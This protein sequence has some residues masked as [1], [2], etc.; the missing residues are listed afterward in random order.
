MRENLKLFGMAHL[1]S[2][3][4]CRRNRRHGNKLEN[5]QPYI[6][7][8]EYLSPARAQKVLRARGTFLQHRKTDRVL[9]FSHGDQAH[10]L[11]LWWLNFRLVAISSSQETVS[12]STTAVQNGKH[13]RVSFGVRAVRNPGS[14]AI[15]WERE[16]TVFLNCFF[17]QSLCSTGLQVS[18]NP[19]T[20]GFVVRSA[21]HDCRLCFLGG[22]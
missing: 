20:A 6:E 13:R 9:A 4:C 3:L 22:Q 7:R 18:C 10:T 19:R 21:W 1:G 11:Y 17:A 16:S 5:V 8:P 14:L 12:P 2:L 15:P